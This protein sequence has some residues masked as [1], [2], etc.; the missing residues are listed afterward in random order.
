MI[1]YQNMIT[2]LNMIAY[3]NI[4]AYDK[5]SWGNGP[6][7]S[8][9]LLRQFLFCLLLSF[10][11]YLLRFEIVLFFILYV[12]P[13]L[14]CESPDPPPIR[15]LYLGNELSRLWSVCL[16]EKASSLFSWKSKMFKVRRPFSNLCISI[17]THFTR[18]RE[19][20]FR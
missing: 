1:A 18:T 6:D 4:I 9:W 15:S 5:D 19:K 20:W 17:F 12:C 7:I 3:Q 16:F 8:I 11:F 10:I 13:V 2:H 14:K